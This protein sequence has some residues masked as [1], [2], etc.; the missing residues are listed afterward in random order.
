MSTHVNKRGPGGGRW[1]AS[2]P[3]SAERRFIFLLIFICNVVE[4]K[5]KIN[6]IGETV[7]KP[8]S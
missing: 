5:C 3:T 7:E 2:N 6:I 8:Y 4:Q 1:R